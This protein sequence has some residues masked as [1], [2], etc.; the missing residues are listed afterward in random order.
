MEWQ[1]DVISLCVWARL[2]VDG[3]GSGGCPA[4]KAALA[5]SIHRL[6]CRTRRWSGVWTE[7]TGTLFKTM[8]APA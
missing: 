6:L 7:G 1:L 4:E 3:D 2:G 5:L 8:L